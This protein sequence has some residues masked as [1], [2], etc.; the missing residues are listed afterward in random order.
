MARNKVHYT[1]DLDKTLAALKKGGLFLAS[2]KRSGESN[3][4]TI[5]WG[6]V[7]TIWG[8]LSFIVLV[9][10]SRY[11]YEFIEDSGEFTVNVPAPGAEMREWL[12][13]CGTKSGRDVDKFTELGMAISPGQNVDSITIDKCPQVY[14]CKVV[15]Y[16]D[17]IPDNLAPD[18]VSGSYPRGDFHRIY[19]GE[20]LGVYGEE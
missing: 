1:H 11:T 17:V 14:E 2:T 10:P 20:I 7:G 8:K 19:F 16:N 13:F 5:G 6:T 4:M 3:V 18:I 12:S 15:H 9:R